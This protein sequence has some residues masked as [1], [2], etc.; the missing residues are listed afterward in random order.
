MLAFLVLILELWILLLHR[1]IDRLQSALRMATRPAASV[2]FSSDEQAAL[3]AV[4]AQLP[5]ALQR[6]GIVRFNPFE[7][8]GG[9]QSFALCIA[10]ANGNGVVI[11]GLYRRNESRVFAKPLVAWLSTYTL[12]NEEK[13]AIG[14][15]RGDAE[16]DAGSS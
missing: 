16:P 8:T 11:N 5:S 13:Q 9:D 15:A 3:A 4:Q 12:S 6:V 7:D 14:R 10:D 2:Q 1:R